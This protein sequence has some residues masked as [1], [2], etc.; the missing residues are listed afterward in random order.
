[1]VERWSLIVSTHAACSGQANRQTLSNQGYHAYKREV[2]V[3][4]RE[5]LMLFRMKRA[6]GL[7]K[8]LV[9]KQDGS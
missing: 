4:Y 7:H 3:L 9:Q 8:H 2:K 1:M 6:V 5:G